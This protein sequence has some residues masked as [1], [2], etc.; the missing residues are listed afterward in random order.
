[1][2]EASDGIMKMMHK[3][4]RHLLFIKTSLDKIFCLGKL[5][6]DVCDADTHSIF[7]FINPFLLS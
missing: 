2:Q 6:S 4:A 1:V 7:N 3:I 5:H